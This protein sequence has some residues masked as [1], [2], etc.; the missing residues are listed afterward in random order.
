[1]KRFIPVHC[2]IIWSVQ[3]LLVTLA[4]LLPGGMSFWFAAASLAFFGLFEAVGVANKR[5]ADTCSESIWALLAVQ[6]G[7][8]T[9]PALVPL[10]FGAFAA[11]GALFV[12]LV[13]GVE[14]M[15]M[16]VWAR[17]VAALFVAVGT[18]LF[19]AFHFTSGSNKLP[20]WAKRWLDPGQG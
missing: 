5:D 12:G 7:R 10:V 11:A 8:P 20:A 17:G 1:M 14:G 2:R 15:S 16:S 18:I 19:L 9:E 4:I 6:N 13:V 3:A